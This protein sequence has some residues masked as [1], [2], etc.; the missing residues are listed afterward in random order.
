MCFHD[1]GGTNRRINYKRFAKYAATQMNLLEKISE[2]SMS[3]SEP[4]IIA[5]VNLFD[6][7]PP[8]RPF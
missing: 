2:T 5:A 8:R 3:S 6:F 4:E 7:K 1:F